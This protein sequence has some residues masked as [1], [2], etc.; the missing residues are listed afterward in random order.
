MIAAASFGLRR[1]GTLASGSIGSGLLGRISEAWPALA[2]PGE[3][4]RSLLATCGLGC[5]CSAGIPF[6]LNRLENL[7]IPYAIR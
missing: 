3:C 6:E 7:R 1:S 4:F 5:F 2:P